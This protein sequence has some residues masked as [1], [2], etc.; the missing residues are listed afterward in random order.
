MVVAVGGQCRNVGKTSLICS[1]I[2]ATPEMQW[3]AVKISRHRHG[4]QIADA[5]LDEEL[6]R[7]SGNDTSRFLRAGA[8]R[9]YWLRAPGDDMAPAAAH[10]R[11][12]ER[13]GPVIVESNSLRSALKPD[14]YAVMLDPRFDDFKES[15][16]KLGPLADAV[17][18]AN[19][20][21]PPL[22]EGQP[23]L[24]MTPDYHCPAL[25]PLLRT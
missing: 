1:L 5:R 22:R 4:A 12:L 24:L 14:L 16:A 3:I 21:V 2:E 15:A 19:G 9:A 18:A 10:V 7:N 13:Q 23:V 17:I 8:V 11:N 25:L 6:D 20:T